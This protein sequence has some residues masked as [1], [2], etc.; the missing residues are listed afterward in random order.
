MKQLIK[1]PNAIRGFEK[2]YFFRKNINQYDWVSFKKW[3]NFKYPITELKLLRT[4][5]DE[6]L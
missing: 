6:N 4:I 2:N 3:L 5:L 1:H